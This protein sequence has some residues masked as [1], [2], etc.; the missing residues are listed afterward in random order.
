MTRKVLS[1]LL[2]TS[3]M[4]LPAGMNI[5]CRQEVAHTETEKEG[6]F[7]GRKREEKT[8]YKNPDGTYST[9]KRTE[10]TNP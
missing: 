5:G 9:E 8:T 3:A 2:L 6:F 7:G 1:A 4:A 10:R